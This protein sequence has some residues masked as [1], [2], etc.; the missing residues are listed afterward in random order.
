MG[1]EDLGLYCRGNALT[2]GSKVQDAGLLHL[3]KTVPFSPLQGSYGGFTQGLPFTAP[4][5]CPCSLGTA[6]TRRLAPTQGPGCSRLV[7]RCYS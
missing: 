7:E 1:Q 3:T 2:L 5:R 6:P 4:T